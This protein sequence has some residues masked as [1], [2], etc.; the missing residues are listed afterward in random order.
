MK[1]QRALRKIRLKRHL[2]Q[3]Q[4]G[5]LLNVTRSCICLTERNG[6]KTIKVAQR[7][8]AVLNCD[9]KELID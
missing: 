2:T 8:A 6:I 4:L 1:N 5:K 9:W 7:Y 3:T